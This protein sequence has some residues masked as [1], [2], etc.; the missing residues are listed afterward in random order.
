MGPPGDTSIT[1]TDTLVFSATAYSEDSLGP[2]EYAW[3]INGVHQCSSTVCTLFTD[4]LSAG[5]CTVSVNV[6]NG[7]EYKENIWYI[8]ILNHSIPPQVLLPQNGTLITGDSIFTW[9]V[10]DPD[11]DTASVLYKIEFYKGAAMDSLIGVSDSINKDT[12]PLCEIID[13]NDLP[14]NQVLSWRIMAYDTLGHA[15]DFSPASTF[16]FFA[17]GANIET[18]MGRLPTEY[19]LA[20]NVP[21]PFNPSTVIRF[22]VPVRIG[23]NSPEGVTPA[24]LSIY[25]IHGK[26]VRQ[27][28]YRGIGPGYYAVTW[29]GR[30]AHGALCPNG[31]YIYKLRMQGFTKSL[32]MFLIK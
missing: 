3:S 16:F 10:T 6:F 23:K 17:S 11:I 7:A 19:A 29:N 13:T 9:S 1:E 27:F 5:I 25:N 30:D 14:E 2:L 24:L 32:K 8:T 22:A 28:S 12:L 20:Q 4:Y 26:L 31:L 18:A 21:N 15:T